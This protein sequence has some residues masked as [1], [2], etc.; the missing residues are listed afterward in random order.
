MLGTICAFTKADAVWIAI[1]ITVGVTLA[2][3]VFAFQ[4]SID[5]TACGG[6]IVALMVALTIAGIFIAILPKTKY[7]MIGYGVAGAVVFSLHIIFDTQMM[8]GGKH[9]YALD[10]EEYV[11]AALNIYLDVIQLFLYILM[12]IRGSSSD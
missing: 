3:T 2:L 1:A 8:I 9:Q 4:T 5:F 7:T 11:F 12:I 10:P 6:V